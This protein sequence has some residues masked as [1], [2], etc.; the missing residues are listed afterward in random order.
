[1]RWH[2][3]K[4]ESA[5]G[6]IFLQIDNL[7]HQLRLLNRFGVFN[8]NKDTEELI[9]QLQGNLVLHVDHRTSHADFSIEGTDLSY[10]TS[11]IESIEAHLHQ[12]G[13]VWTLSHC[14]LDEMKCKGEAMHQ[15]DKWVIPAFDLS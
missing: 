12:E 11:R 9:R 15:G 8:L 10:D 3:G 14:R 5:Q 13:S 7:A 1:M 2:L 4:I 6:V